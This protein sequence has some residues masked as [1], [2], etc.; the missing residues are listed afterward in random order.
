MR[1]LVFLEVMD[2]GNPKC[3]RYIDGFIKPQSRYIC[4]NHG[5]ACPRPDQFCSVRSEKL[6]E[7]GIESSDF[8]ILE[9]SALIKLNEWDS[10]IEENKKRYKRILRMA[11]R[12]EKEGFYCKPFNYKLFV[13][14]VVAVNQ[15]KTHRQRNEMKAHYRESVEE[16]GGYPDKY[17]DF[18]EPECQLHSVVMLG[19]FER[20]EGH[21]QGEIQTDERLVG[22]INFLRVGNIALYSQILGHGD[23][24]NKGV[25]YLLHLYAVERGISE[26]VDFLMYTAWVSGTEGLQYWKRTNLFQPEDLFLVEQTDDINSA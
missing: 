16:R 4:F 18:E 3:R 22:Y 2:C 8:R 7:S 5:N 9:K 15:S 21:K 17:Y 25:M 11:R 6:L 23:Y 13:P 14:D 12:A 19:V 26:G 1:I 24:L 10:L 20:V